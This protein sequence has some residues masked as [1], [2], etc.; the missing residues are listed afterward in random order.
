MNLDCRNCGA[1]LTIGEHETQVTC[2]YCQQV[3]GMPGRAPQPAP[4]PPRQVVVSRTSTPP[5]AARVVIIVAV[6]GMLVAGM[7]VAMVARTASR[8]ATPPAPAVSQAS[9]QLMREKAAAERRVMEARARAEAAAQAATAESQRVQI[10]AVATSAPIDA[11][12]ASAA[13]EPRRRKRAAPKA[14]E[15]TGPV[16]SK[17]DA[18]KALEPELQSCMKQAGVYYLITRLGNDRKGSSV[19]P[20]HLTGTSVVDY[21]PTP[22]FAKTPLGKCVA[23]AGAAVRAPAYRGNYIYFGLHNDAVADPLAGAPNELNQAKAKKALSALDDEARDCATS[24][25]KGSRPGER[26]TLLATFQGVTGRV[27]KVELLYVDRKSPYAR[28]VAEVYGKAST[29]KFKRIESRVTYVL[30]P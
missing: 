28:C 12:S 9:Q 7:V 18:Q 20:L 15:Y 30:K 2:P 21:V 1:S 29:D 14:P 8:V 19:P 5:A 23:R 17:A 6:V 26:T 4:P 22:G 16:L 27:S 25:A 3:N 11:G 13:S 24:H 10:A